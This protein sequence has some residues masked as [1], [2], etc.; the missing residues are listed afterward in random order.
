[1]QGLGQQG[2]DA[3]RWPNYAVTKEEHAELRS[4]SIQ[5]LITSIKLKELFHLKERE[6]EEREREGERGGEREMEGRAREGGREGWRERGGE[7]R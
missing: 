6:M 7:S 3:A 1:M 5:N 2:W 4:R